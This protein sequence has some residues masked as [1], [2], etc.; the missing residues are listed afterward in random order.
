MCTYLDVVVCT[1]KEPNFERKEKTY[2]GGIALYLQYGWIQLKNKSQSAKCLILLLVCSYLLDSFSLEMLAFGRIY[3]SYAVQN[4]RTKSIFL[5]SFRA[6]KK[7]EIYDRMC[8]EMVTIPFS[9]CTIPRRIARSSSSSSSPVY[10]LV[11][12][13]EFFVVW[14]LLLSVHTNTQDPADSH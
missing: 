3:L 12:A 14:V 10:M 6:T 4:I 8:F 13:K 1:E 7:M 9:F 5:S 11:K 2:F